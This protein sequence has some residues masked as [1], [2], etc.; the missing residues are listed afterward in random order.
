MQ[1]QINFLQRKVILHSY[2]YYELNDNAISDK[3]YDALCKEL[4]R[5]VVV[6]RLAI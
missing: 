5:W 2:I 4:V 6:S 1:E 3:D